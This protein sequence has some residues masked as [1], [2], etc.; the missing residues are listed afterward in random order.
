MTTLTYDGTQVDVS[1]EGFL[2]DSAQWTPEVADE[3]AR[4]AGLAPLTERH[5]KVVTLCREDAARTGRSPGL[6]RLARL[7][8]VGVEEL[9]RLFPAEPAT[10][11]AR[12]AGLPKPTTGQRRP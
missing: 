6:R 2:V 1:A 5:W 3:L 10:L 8:G 12:I 4:E 9:H 7:S 11:A